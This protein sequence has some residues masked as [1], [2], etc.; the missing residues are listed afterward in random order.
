MLLSSPILLN[1]SQ[2]PP[3][4]LSVDDTHSVGESS[5]RLPAGNNHQRVPRP[6][7]L[8]VPAEVDGVLNTKLHVL[9][10][11]SDP[12]GGVEQR[13]DAAMEVAL[14]GHLR[15]PRH[16]DDGARRPEPGAQ[17]GRI[18]GSGEEEGGAESRNAVICCYDTAR[19]IFF[20]AY[21]PW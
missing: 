21:R 7:D 16:C 9:Q 11:V 6:D 14:A 3:Q 20:A 10:P 1:T 2:A 15:E 19:L 8:A 4:P 5:S 17:R 13:E 18:R 12:L